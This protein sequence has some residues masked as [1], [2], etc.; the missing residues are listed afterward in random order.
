MAASVTPTMV[1]GR[2]SML[3]RVLYNDGYY[4]YVKPQ[5]LDQLIEL[6]GIISFYRQSGPAVLGVDRVR[7]SRRSDYDGA[8]RRVPV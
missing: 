3:I 8:E 4:D 7:S 2:V 5:L 1:R 6:N